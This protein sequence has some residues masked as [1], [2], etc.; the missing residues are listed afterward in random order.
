MDTKQYL[1]Q[2]N[3]LN[4]KITNKLFEKFQLKS[5]ICSVS[6]SVKDVNVQSGHT[7]DRTGDTICKIIDLER[8]IDAMVDEFADT[9]AHIISQIEQL[10]FKYYDVLFKRYVAIK[11]WNEISVEMSLTR[12]HV[13]KIHQ[14]A[15][16][17]FE[18][19]FGK[20]YM[21]K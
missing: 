4:R 21:D 20:E 6:N 16:E 5:M 8:E 1:S 17:Q 18:K 9:K 14:S 2:I 3:I 12:R 7:G 10:D 11:N 19:K 15:L 13:F